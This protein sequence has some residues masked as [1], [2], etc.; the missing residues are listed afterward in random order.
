MQLPS[1]EQD[2]NIFKFSL[3]EIEVI[4]VLWYD[5]IFERIQLYF[6][7]GLIIKIKILPILF[8]H[9]AYVS[10][11]SI[12]IFVIGESSLVEYINVNLFISFPLAID[13]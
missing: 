13:L 2:I 12:I 5:N 8:A 1:F 7:S 10:D 4:S 3:R 11:S 6:F 9:I